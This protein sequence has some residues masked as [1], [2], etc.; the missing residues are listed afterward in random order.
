MTSTAVERRHTLCWGTLRHLTL[1]ELIEVAH[2][3][4]Y[5]AVTASV[6]QHGTEIREHASR[7]N[8]LCRTTGVRIECVEPIISPLP[9]L[10]D[11]ET[12]PE[13]LRVFLDHDAD[14]VIECAD[15]VRARSVNVAHF[16]GSSHDLD[17]LASSVGSL[18][19]RADQ[20][21]LTATVEFIPGTGIATL[22]DAL[23]V[24]TAGGHPNCRLLIDAWHLAASGA[25]ASDLDQIPS[26]LIHAVQL[27]DK[28]DSPRIGASQFSHRQLPGHGTFPLQAFIAAARRNSPNVDLQV[29]V[30][31]DELPATMTPD[32]IATAAHT[33]LDSLL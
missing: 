20:R 33:S 25:T 32:E 18:V 14:D 8:E 1:T 9:G 3:T 28:S 6:V 17:D 24:I 21:G 10:R 4:G 15:L 23:H 2:R 30:F 26:G 12:V 5:A 7:L 29:E 16:L 19:A 13:A 11:R 27:C 22:G 31:N